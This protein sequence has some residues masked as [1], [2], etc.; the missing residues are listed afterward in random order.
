MIDAPEHEVPAMGDWLKIFTPEKLDFVIRSCGFVRT[1][2]FFDVES[3]TEHDVKVMCRVLQTSYENLIHELETTKFRGNEPFNYAA[4][5][6]GCRTRGIEKTLTAIPDLNVIEYVR[7][8]CIARTI[9][10]TQETLLDT[11]R[12]LMCQTQSQ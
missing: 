1:L 9:V 8:R 7:I 3:I 5:L 11:L 12:D 4:F 2:K 10:T 6:V